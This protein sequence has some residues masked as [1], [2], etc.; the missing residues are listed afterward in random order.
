[1][2]D[3]VAKSIDRSPQLSAGTKRSMILRLWDEMFVE[4]ALREDQLLRL[5]YPVIP[6]ALLQQLVICGCIEL[7]LLEG[8]L[9]PATHPYRAALGCW[10]AIDMM[11]AARSQVSP[12]SDYDVQGRSRFRSRRQG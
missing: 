7:P 12:W 5:P 4:Y 8:L 2:F 9:P 1:M 3:E 10:S 11:G 6:A